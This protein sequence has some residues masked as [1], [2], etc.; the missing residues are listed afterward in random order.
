[1]QNGVQNARDP[2]NYDGL[3]LISVY[4]S[5]YIHYT[6]WDEISYPFPNLKFGNG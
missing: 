5:N 3:T 6:M 1:M 4:M 2:I